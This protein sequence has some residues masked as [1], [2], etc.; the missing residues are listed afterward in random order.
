M[1]AFI[2]RRLGQSLLVIAVMATLVFLG[3]YL[4]GNPIDILINPEADQLERE[5]AIVRLGLD[6]P[7]WTQ[8][9]LFVASAFSGNLGT[10]F[11]H[12]VPA[13][14]LILDRMPATMELAFVALVIAVGLGIPLALVAG[15]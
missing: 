7:L 2:L 15:L 10:S 5:R 3:V 12:G 13:V 9:G 11:V 14:G 4:L 1:L 8:F 6:R